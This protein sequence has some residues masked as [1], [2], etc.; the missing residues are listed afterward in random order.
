MA[1]KLAADQQPAWTACCQNNPRADQ[2]CQPI[3]ISPQ[4]SLTSGGND[5]LE[6]N[7]ADL[8]VDHHLWREWTFIRSSLFL[9]LNW[10][11]KLMLADAS[12]T[13]LMNQ[14]GFISFHLTTDSLFPVNSRVITSPPKMSFLLEAIS[15]LALIINP[16][17]ILVTHNCNSI[18][19]IQFYICNCVSSSICTNGD[20]I[21]QVG[22][23]YSWFGHDCSVP[24]WQQWCEVVS[25][26][27]LHWA[28][29]LA[30]S[31]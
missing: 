24:S 17:L 16:R 14:V 9:S 21:C 31:L 19:S 8:R 7:T 5:E 1:E 28:S 29:F 22:T 13:K 25:A 2:P 18:W 11:T 20:G 27:P 15:M 26:L 12:V 10:C 30:L 4:L 23:G 6:P 3:H